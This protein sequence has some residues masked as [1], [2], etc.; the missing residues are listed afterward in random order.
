ME[1]LNEFRII[2]IDDNPEIHKDFIK[3]LTVETNDS[4]SKLDAAL[5]DHE[6]TSSTNPV[7]PKFIIDTALQGMD[8]VEIIRQSLRNN[9]RYCIAFVDIR[10]PPG[11][12][13]IETIRKIWAIDPDVQAVICTAYS[14]YS[15]EE[16]VQALG[17][18]ENLLILKK[19]FDT[20][21]VRQLATSLAYRWYSEQESKKKIKAL[22]AQVS[23]K[24]QTK[25]SRSSEANSNNLKDDILLALE[26]NEFFLQFMPICQ[27]DSKAICEIEALLRWRHPKLGTIQANDFLGI[28]EEVGLIVPLGEWYLKN[29][30]EY[31]VS[32]KG[33]GSA[34][35]KLLVNALPSQFNQSNFV[36]TVS[37]N[38]KNADLQAERLI[39]QI[40]EKAIV[41]HVEVRE[42]LLSLDALGVTIA[43]NDFGMEN[44]SL[45]YLRSM[46]ISQIR[47]HSDMVQHIE[48]NRNDEM[49]VQAI[50]T[51]TKNLRIKVVAEGVSNDRQFQFLQNRGCQLIQGYFHKTPLSAMEMTLALEKTHG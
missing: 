19:P 46:P 42:A 7:L 39:L 17:A 26:R 32:L 13:G 2:I 48:S 37:K 12:D 22:E 40:G 14:D 34:E 18:R 38:L 1:G 45:Q 15:W 21:A 49:F 20:S 28:A 41:K 16:T 29:A 9:E 50:L 23:E 6:I 44:V 3:I 27:L 25:S 5:F 8:G 33:K 4:F 36:E 31:F 24:S 10:M 35:L 51:M 11:L 47:L 43:L 30:C